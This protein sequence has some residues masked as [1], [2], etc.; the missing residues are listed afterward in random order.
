MT[1]L[2]AQW[3]PRPRIQHPWPNQ[4]FAVKYPRGSGA[5]KPHVR[6]CAGCALKRIESSL[7]EMETAVKPS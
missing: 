7:L 6:F 5:E 4:R 2:V 1:K 3:L